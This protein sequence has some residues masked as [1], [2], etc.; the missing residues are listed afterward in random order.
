MFFNSHP[1]EFFPGTQINILEFPD[2]VAG[3][4]IIRKSFTGPIT[5]QLTDALAHLKNKV[6]TQVVVKQKGQARSA[7]AWNYPYEAIEELLPNAVY[8]RSY[9]E[10][11]PI[12]VRVEPERLTIT[13][14][15]GP[16]RSIKIS[17]LKKGKLIARR[18]RNR[19][20]GDLLRQIDLAEEAGTGIPTTIEAMKING[21]PPPTSK[22]TKIALTSR[23]FCRFIRLSWGALRGGHNPRATPPCKGANRK[24]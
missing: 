12:E 19:R 13:S 24:Y 2:G 9:E 16:D 3:T 22:L 11:E 17:D 1:E 20:V 14:Y 5:Q 4:R 8:H 15:P 23:R 6:L 18:Y 21:S 7:K 10:R